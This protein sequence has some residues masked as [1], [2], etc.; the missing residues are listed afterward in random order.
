[1]EKIIISEDLDLWEAWVDLQSPDNG[2]AVLY[3]IGDI[4]VGKSITNPVLVKK[5]VQ[6]GAPDHLYLEILPSIVTE[7]GRLTEIF[8]AERLENIHQYKK[9]HICVGEEVVSEIADI[10]TIY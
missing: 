5:N 10:E 4:F 8:Y 3:V 7:Y 6:G 2:R 9:V 1:M